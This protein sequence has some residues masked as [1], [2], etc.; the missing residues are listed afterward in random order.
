MSIWTFAC[1]L[2]HIFR[3]TILHVQ[4]LLP[5][6]CTVFLLLSVIIYCFDMLRPQLLEGGWKLW[7]KHVGAIINNHKIMY[8]KLLII[9]AHVIQ[10]NGKCTTIMSPVRIIE[11][12][13]IH[14]FSNL[15]WYK[16][17]RVFSTLFWYTTLHVSERLTVHHQESWYC[18]HSNWYLSY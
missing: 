6:W 1:L 5:T 3:S 8:N 16:T 4:Y 18:I 12:N 15:F 9:T 7:L 14:Y 2:L 13:K 11:A 10:F 17:L